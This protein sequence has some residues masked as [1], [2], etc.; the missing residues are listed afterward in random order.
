LKDFLKELLMVL[1]KVMLLLWV[2]LK[3][4]ARDLALGRRRVKEKATEKN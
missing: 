4:S 3:A 1:G 2:L